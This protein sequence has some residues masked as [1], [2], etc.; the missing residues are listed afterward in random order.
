M[1]TFKFLLKI[2]AI[3]FLAF[4]TVPPAFAQDQA[5]KE[6]S[7]AVNIHDSNMEWGKCPEFIPSGCKVAILQGDPTSNN[8]DAVF[9]FE[10]NTD[11][12]EH[13]HNSAE[14]MILLE[15]ELEV[16]YEGEPTK[17]LKSGYYAY[18]PAKKP[19]SARCNDSGPCILFVAFEKPLD[20]FP[21]NGN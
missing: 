2:L 14:H 21:G 8:S 13:W 18:G 7:I 1:K 6:T 12:P 10:P 9:K 4:V 17:T 20:A 16:T 5:M 11:I 3:F 15:G 19:H